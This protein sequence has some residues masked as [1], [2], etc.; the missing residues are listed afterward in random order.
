MSCEHNNG[1]CVKSK[2]K[3]HDLFFPMKNKIVPTAGVLVLKDGKVL[4]VRHGEPAE[5]LDGKY[6]L[7]AGRI[8]DKENEKEAA[9]RELKEE[10]GIDVR[11]EDLALLPGKWE[12]GIERK[13]GKERFSL[14]V[15]LAEK[16][17]GILCGNAETI[18][19][20]VDL[21]DTGNYDLLP[22]T[23]NIISEGLNFLQNQLRK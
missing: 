22:N 15:F 2:Q 14:K 10:T 23:G 20:W 17:E 11:A 3:F 18:P 7:P 21:K 12:A 13:N 19:E 6:G 9:R 5:H 8:K 4:L 1:I 16:F